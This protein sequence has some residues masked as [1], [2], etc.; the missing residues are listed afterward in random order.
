MIPTQFTLTSTHACTPRLSSD[1]L[2]LPLDRWHT[3]E[4]VDLVRFNSDGKIAAIREYFDTRLIHD[5]VL[6]HEA[7]LKKGG[8]ESSGKG[9][10]EKGDKGAKEIGG[11]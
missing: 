1:H 11:E 6:E 8:E 3:L 4:L 2:L 10:E 5:L 9:A 7:S